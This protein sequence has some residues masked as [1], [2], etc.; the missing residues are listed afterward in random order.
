[1]VTPTADVS[2]R[3]ALAWGALGAAA[4]LLYLITPVAS[5]VLIGTLL[6]FL[7]QP[8]FARLKRLGETGAA[9]VTVTVV[10]LLLV[11]FL[12][13]SGWLVA[14]RG[15]VH[16]KDLIVA[17]G[18]DA[19]GGGVLKG[20]ARLTE[21]FGF[22][23]DDLGQ[24]LRST[25]E[26]AGTWLASGAQTLLTATANTLLLLFFI[27]LSMYFVLINT[28]GIVGTATTV[29]PLRPEWTAML[30]SEFRRVGK[31]ILFGTFAAGLIQGA[32]ATLGY[33]IAGVED[34]IFY[35]FATAFASLVPA[36]GTL[37]VW[38]P[39]GVVLVFSG[40]PIGGAVV[41]IWGA[42]VVV[43]LTDYVLRPRLI[44]GESQLPSLFM[45]VALFGGVEVFGLKGLIVGP[46]LMS[47]AIAV[48][49]LYVAEG[50]AHRPDPSGRPPS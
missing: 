20:L 4:L 12:F 1:V 9:V 36:V 49:R 18:P 7:A 41:L 22:T 33:W 35:G 44:G 26:G 17:F 45:F 34:P 42:L 11:G 6:A 13:G 38:V 32:L 28:G 46:L 40:H 47:L 5:G 10:S 50:L 24:R 29:L 8:L 27:V 19:P 39:L 43:F 15:T 25:I 3:R 16:S 48:I 21:P 31:T 30:F 37:V 14:S 2:E 23:T